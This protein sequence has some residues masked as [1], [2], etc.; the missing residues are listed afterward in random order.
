[1]TDRYRHIETRLR[2]AADAFDYPATP[3]IAGA[4]MR[5]ISAPAGNR[6]RIAFASALAAAILSL[7]IP[8]VRSAMLQWIE[9][10]VVRITAWFGA[11]TPE[12]SKH[13]IWSDQMLLK[14]GELTTL[15]QAQRAVRYRIQL[16]STGIGPPT[17]V[18]LQRQPGGDS[19]VLL[20]RNAGGEPQMVLH[21]I[22][23]RPGIWKGVRQIDQV[24]V[25][26]RPAVWAE[27]PHFIRLRDGRDRAWSIIEDHVLI[28]TAQDDLTF[29][30]ESRLSKAAAIQ[31]AE[32]LQAFTGKEK[33]Q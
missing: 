11:E 15:E 6:L 31:T 22:G 2:R 23:G 28:W 20:W 5:S 30:L 32:S 25:N 3:D 12:R 13:T 24:Q 33:T 29:R 18:Y 17:E 7:A 19:V 10:G 9:I 1:M 4:V 8:P 21:H 14:A 26:G 27:G 16:P